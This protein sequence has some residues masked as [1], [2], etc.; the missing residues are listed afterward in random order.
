V[1][2]WP[3]YNRSL[4]RRGEILFAY[5]FLDIWDSELATMNENKE[6]KRYRYP[7]SLILVIGYIRIYF[8]LPYRQTEGIIKATG[9]NMP[10]H[11]SYGQICRR[12]SR[13][14]ID[15]SSSRTEEDDDD[16]DSDIVIA[17]DSTGIKVTNRGQWLRDKWNIRKKGYLKIHVAVNVKTKEILSLE[18]TDE[19]VHDAKVMDKLVENILKSNNNI[20]INSVLAD[21]SYDSNKNFKYLCEKKILPGIKIRKNSITSPK[22][23]NTRNKE[24][25][26]Q[27][28]FDRWKKKRKYGHRWMAETA[29]SSIKRSYG[30]YTSATKFKN[31]VKEM[32]LKVSLYNLFRRMT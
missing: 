19:K 8:H 3:S 27:Q 16:D 14:D 1:T 11:P 2:C 4:V 12:L 5:D 31:M 7:N 29:F 28:Y 22:N 30:E 23:T 26:S 15:S 21:G 17:I 20:N 32:I 9:K 24:V 13:L 25:I 6:G 10:D 18:V